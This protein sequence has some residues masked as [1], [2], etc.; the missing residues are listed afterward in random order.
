[1]EYSFSEEE[2]QTSLLVRVRRERHNF[3]F[4]FN[5]NGTFENVEFSFGAGEACSFKLK[6]SS[7]YSVCG[8]MRIPKHPDLESLTLLVLDKDSNVLCCIAFEDVQQVFKYHQEIPVVIQS[9]EEDFADLPDGI[10]D[11]YLQLDM[12]HPDLYFL[13]RWEVGLQIDIAS[14]TTFL[15]TEDKWNKLS[16]WLRFSGSADIHTCLVDN[17]HMG[18]KVNRPT[19]EFRLAYAEGN[20][21]PSIVRLTWCGKQC[22][23]WKFS[24]INLHYSPNN[25]LSR[26]WIGLITQWNIPQ[27]ITFPYIKLK[28]YVHN[29]FLCFGSCPNCNTHFFP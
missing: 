25:H 1:M 20:N 15:P 27:I 22:K 26:L 19:G 17:Q 14:Q 5:E 2:L 13:D 6:C 8:S 12:L 11:F 24:S 28:L 7:P 4:Q 21:A 23:T 3:S 16:C 29:F 18:L 10:V 9:C